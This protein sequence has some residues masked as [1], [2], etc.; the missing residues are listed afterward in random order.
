MKTRL[1]IIERYHAALREYTSAV[2]E[3]GKTK[4]RNSPEVLERVDKAHRAC[5]EL[6]KLLAAY[7]HPQDPHAASGR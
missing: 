3:L 6:R 7:D 5:E 4:D 2:A 1:A